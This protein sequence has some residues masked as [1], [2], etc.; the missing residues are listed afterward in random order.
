MAAKIPDFDK[1][2][3]NDIVFFRIMTQYVL[4]FHKYHPIKHQ[5]NILHQYGGKIKDGRQKT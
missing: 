5:N 4:S 1:Y 3:Y 2:Y